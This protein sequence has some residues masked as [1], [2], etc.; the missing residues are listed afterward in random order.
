MSQQLQYGK[1]G[2]F[3]CALP[4]E[5]IAAFREPPEPCPSLRAAVRAALAQPLDDFPSFEQLF[6]PE[7]HVTLAVDRYT[8]GAPEI[9]AEVWSA[10]A[11]RSIA[12]ADTVILQPVGLPGPALGDP[13]GQLPR[14]VAAQIRWL[15]HDPTDE[16]ELAYL[17]TAV[18]GERIYLARILVE[19]EVAVSIGE[20][21][22][23]PVMGLRGTGSAFYPGMSSV[24]AMVRTHG[25]GHSELG[26]DDE[27]PLR[28]L[29]DEVTWLLG[30][31]FSIQ[32]FPGAGGQVA[33]VLAGPADAVF[34][35]GR[36]W[37]AD[38]ALVQLPERCPL[39]VVAIDADAA[40]HGW[41]QF[42][43]A[44]ETAHHLVT[45]GGRIVVLSEIEAELD[46]GFK[47]LQEAP[48]V[49]NALQPLRKMAPPDLIPATQLASAAD[50]AK[51]YFLSK[52]PEGTVESLS[53]TALGSDKE[54]ARLL[55]N[56]SDRCVLIG[57]AQHTFGKV[58]C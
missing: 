15:V 1:T 57:G 54:V 20:M 28:Q 19:A 25:Q 42:G 5:R 3:T 55:S 18:Q 9:I 40:G 23:D 52:L 38:N 39:V 7:D 34:R 30:N 16:K 12:A 22:Y 56:S 27:R 36:R 35:E 26:P 31:Q 46:D 43:A 8:P 50:W 51:I 41:E 24:D 10:L 44:I 2:R 53:M 14:E 29:V 32:V 58:G 47:L 33:H 11:S 6:V 37:L 45:R 49:R 13:R 4:P 48:Q 21:R 17:A